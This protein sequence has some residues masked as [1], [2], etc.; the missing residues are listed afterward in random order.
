MKRIFA[1]PF[2]LFGS[3]AMFFYVALPQISNEKKAKEAFLEAEIQ[4]N[5]RQAYF[6]NLENL[7]EEAAAYQNTLSKIEA[8]FPGELS[9]AEIIEFFNRKAENNGLLL[10][11]LA[12][13]AAPPEELQIEQTEQGEQAIPSEKSQVQYFSLALSGSSSSL[14]NFI[15]DIETS[16]RLADI[17]SV[18]LQQEESQGTSSSGANVLVKVYY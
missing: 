14:E 18:S 3:F 8:A 12:P 11:S 5:Q 13:S 4:L 6:S 7:L 16:S 2:L 17:E 1:I 9:L 10:K 15:K